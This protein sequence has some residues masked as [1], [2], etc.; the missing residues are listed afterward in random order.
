MTVDLGP[1]LHL[2]AR[3][4][5][6]RALL[7]NILVKPQR[8]AQQPVLRDMI[9]EQA[10]L[11]NAYVEHMLQRGLWVVHLARPI[12]ILVRRVPH[13][14]APVSHVPQGR[15]LVRVPH[16]ALLARRDNILL[17]VVHANLALQESI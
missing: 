17:Q 9:V 16:H 14:L 7:D 10:P 5:V 13:Q 4:R 12:D 11:Q 15:L 2:Q 1:I 6:L 3:P 8:V